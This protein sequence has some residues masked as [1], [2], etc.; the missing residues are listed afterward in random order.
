MERPIQW[1]KK[2][3]REYPIIASKLSSFG[4]R[5]GMKQA[6]QIWW[7]RFMQS[8]I[9]SKTFIQIN[10]TR[11]TNTFYLFAYLFLHAFYYILKLK[12]EANLTNQIKFS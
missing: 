11:K 1:F 2:S 4:G 6:F 9:I 10:F 12:F 3:F 8:L 7:N 5:E